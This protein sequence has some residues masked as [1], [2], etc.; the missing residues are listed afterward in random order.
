MFSHVVKLNKLDLF[1]NKVM[2]SQ[3]ICE[4]Y[5]RIKEFQEEIKKH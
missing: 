5:L 3:Y 2:N 1:Q 4:M